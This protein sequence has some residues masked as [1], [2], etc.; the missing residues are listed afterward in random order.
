MGSLDLG[1]LDVGP[2]DMATLDFL[3]LDPLT[4]D[5]FLDITAQETM[6]TITHGW[7]SDPYSKCSERG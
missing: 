5:S 1:P 6:T 3:I 2:H 7:F 4:W